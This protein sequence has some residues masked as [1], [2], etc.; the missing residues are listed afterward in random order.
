LETHSDARHGLCGY[1][2]AAT[3]ESQAIGRCRLDAHL[4]GCKAEN[5]CDPSLHR[6]TVRADPRLLGNDRAVDMVNGRAALVQERSGVGQE[7]V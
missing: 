3:G 2:F 1:P 7:D 6:R 4:L 5:V